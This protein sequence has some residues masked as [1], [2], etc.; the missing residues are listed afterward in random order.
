MYTDVINLLATIA[1]VKNIASL[2]KLLKNHKLL[3]CK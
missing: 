3:H 2:Q 1:D